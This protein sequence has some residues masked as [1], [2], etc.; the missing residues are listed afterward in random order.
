MHF[1]GIIEIFLGRKAAEMVFGEKP[2]DS[3]VGIS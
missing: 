1:G 2:E 3:D